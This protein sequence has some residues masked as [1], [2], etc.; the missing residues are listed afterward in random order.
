[1]SEDDHNCEKGLKII[2]RFPLN[3]AK[4]MHDQQITFLSSNQRWTHTAHFLCCFTV[5]IASNIEACAYLSSAIFCRHCRDVRSDVCHG[6]TISSADFLRK[7]NHAHK[8]WPTLSIVGPLLKR[9]CVICSGHLADDTRTAL[10]QQLKEA[11][12]RKW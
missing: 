10:Y 9:C 8:S 4:Q 7:L 5:T 11:D 3:L 2:L 12:G 6:S 1:L